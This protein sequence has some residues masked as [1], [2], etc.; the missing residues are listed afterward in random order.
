MTD[1]RN[2]EDPPDDDSLSA[3]E[4]HELLA[5][6]ALAQGSPHD[7]ALAAHERAWEK[8]LAAEPEATPEELAAMARDDHA[9]LLEALRAAHAP[10]VLSPVKHEQL[11][12][13]VVTPARR[14]RPVTWAASG[15]ALAAAV[16]LA[17]RFVPATEHVA[18]TAPDPDAELSRSTESIVASAAAAGASTRVDRIAQARSGDYRK[19]RFRSWGAR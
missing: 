1:S 6:L 11:V 15:L 9:E 3:E 7:D 13:R 5:A 18:A 10:G 16:L 8:A 12:R 14:V 4:E 19:N 17:V 2:P